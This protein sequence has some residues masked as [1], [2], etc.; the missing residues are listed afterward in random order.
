[1]VNLSPAALEHWRSACLHCILWLTALLGKELP[2]N[3]PQ[4]LS[5]GEAGVAAILPKSGEAEWAVR[6]TAAW[7]PG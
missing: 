2:T 3:Y 1:M 4:R 7:P 5:G 6:L